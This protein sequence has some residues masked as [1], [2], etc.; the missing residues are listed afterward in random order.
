MR[1]QQMVGLFVAG[2]FALWL[3]HAGAAEVTWERV[4]GGTDWDAGHSVQQTEDGGFIVAGVA[5]YKQGQPCCSGDGWLIKTDASGNEEWNKLFGG[6]AWDVFYSVQQTDD[7]GFIAVGLTMSFGAGA[8]DI[9]LVKTDV[10]GNQLWSKTFGGTSWD[11]GWSVQ[12]TADGGFVVLGE[13]R[14]SG[15][16]LIDTWLIKT[17]ALGNKEWSK[18]FGG[19]ED[20]RCWLVQQTADG[21][22][23]MA[24]ETRSFGAGNWDGGLVKTDVDGLEEWSRTFGGTDWDNLRSVQQ[25]TDGGFI[26]A[27]DTWSSGAGL[28]DAWLIKTDALGNEELSKTFGGTDWDI[29]WSVQQTTDGGFIIAGGSSGPDWGDGWLIKTDASGNEEWNKFFGG[30]AWDYFR[31]VQQTTDG[32]FIVAGLLDC[33]YPDPWWGYS[34]NLYL[35]YYKPDEGL[36]LKVA[37]D[38]KPGSDPNSINLK[39]KGKLPVAIL[40]DEGFDARLVDVKTVL[41]ADPELFDLGAVPVAPIWSA[42]EDVNGDGLDDLLVFFSVPELAELAAEAPPAFDSQSLEAVLTGATFDGIEII[43]ADSVRIVPPNDRGKKGK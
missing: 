29:A 23:I 9:Y 27:G 36:P 40:S 4:Y 25:T 41:F 16:G 43:G 11:N 2:T 31:S 13:T 32:G 5:G 17:D 39:S 20:D 14:S 15:A 38:I 3:S 28:G 18:T 10:D 30:T 24:G 6:T 35:V 7:R 26:V 21:G 22:F 19:Y 42:V 33:S 8:Y 1:R 34:G 37:I 12:Q